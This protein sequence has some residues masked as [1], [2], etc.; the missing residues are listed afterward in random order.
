MDE[1]MS[2][3]QTRKCI[4]KYKKLD[5]VCYMANVGNIQG[6]LTINE[7]IILFDPSFNDSNRNLSP[8]GTANYFYKNFQEGQILK[9][10]AC[11]C[12]KDI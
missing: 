1:I 4:N 11:V 2:N 7:D 6:T 10:Q 12:F 5:P 8:I 9:Y 3:K